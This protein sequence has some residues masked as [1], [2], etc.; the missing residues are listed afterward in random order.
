M[1]SVY[2]HPYFIGECF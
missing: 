2:R 1:Q